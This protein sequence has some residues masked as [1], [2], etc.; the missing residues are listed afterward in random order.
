MADDTDFEDI[1]ELG[2]EEQPER[3]A[4][5]AGAED[6]DD[7]D[8]SDEPAT[9]QAKQGPQPPTKRSTI[10]KGERHLR[11]ATVAAMIVNGYRRRDIIAKVNADY[12]DAWDNLSERG[13]ERLISDANKLIAAEAAADL[14]VEKGKAIR[15]LNDLYRKSTNAKLYG[16][17]LRVQTRINRMLGLDAPLSVRHGNDPDNPMPVPQTAGPFIVIVQ[18]VDEK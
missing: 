18:E 6:D 12:F 8:L 9:W 10:T 2:D 14:S 1:D 4:G 3:P 15:R 16:T 7:L 17:A 11:I 13:I 5:G